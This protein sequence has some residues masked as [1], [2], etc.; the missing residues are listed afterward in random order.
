MSN[1][2]YKILP[3]GIKIVHRISSSPVVYTG[4]M[5]GTGTRDE[6]EEENGMAHYIEH[7]VFK[8]CSELSPLSSVRSCSRDLSA[9]Q[10]IDRIEGI[11]GDINAYTTKEETV[12]YAATPEAYFSRTLA[13]I[14]SMV[15]C[16]TFPKSETD[17]EVGVIL[18]EIESCN[19]CPSELIYDDFE[20][21][22][23]DGNALARPI[24]GTKKTLRHISKDAHLALEWMHSHY[25]PERIVIFSQG[26]IPFSK[27]L[28]TIE[29]ILSHTDLSSRTTSISR[30]FPTEKS[31]KTHIYKKHTHQVHAMLGGR[32]YS[33]G[34]K[35]H[36]GLYL[37]N[38][39]LGGG[40]MSSRLNMNLREKKGWVYSIE[41]IYAHLSDCGYWSIYFASDSKNKDACLEQCRKELKKLREQTMSTAQWTRSLKQLHGQMAIMAENQE[42]SVLAMAKQMLYHS[43]TQDWETAFQKI[44]QFTPTDLQ[45]IANEVYTDDNQWLLTYE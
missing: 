26:N 19:D 28:N 44:S 27:I 41:S 14:A 42:N 31:T 18:E 33:L 3:S 12:F 22:I 45:D 34:H 2:F 4:I 39:I 17:K 6:I 38:N 1:T 36:L 5:V 29:H 23:F 13:L 11:G 15:F 9:K 40:S 43:H 20:S 25:T 24:L 21:L 8:G 32:A 10:I 37:L 30:V 7:C 16:P 35:K